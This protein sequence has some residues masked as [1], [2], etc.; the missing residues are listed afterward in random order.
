[1]EK[2][3]MN[4]KIDNAVSFR[5]G[6]AVGMVGLAI[7]VILAGFFY[8]MTSPTIP[9]EMGQ[10]IHNPEQ[11][12]T[13]TQ[14]SSGQGFNPGAIL[15]LP[16]ALVAIGVLVMLI[17]SFHGYSAHIRKEHASASLQYNKK[18][19]IE[20]IVITN[21]DDRDVRELGRLVHWSA[22]R[23]RV[24]LGGGR[25]LWTVDAPDHEIRMGLEYVQQALR[26]YTNPM[27]DRDGQKKK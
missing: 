21:L 19:L 10:P 23:K 7:L 15:I 16:V 5:R 17:Q 22:G 26:D 8:R 4:D 1:M 20:G 13:H 6:C 25:W 12:H 3:K 11:I 24:N 18:G 9:N 14:A 27:K 2:I